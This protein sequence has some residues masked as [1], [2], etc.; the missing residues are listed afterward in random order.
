MS[1]F[2]S[3][4]WRHGAAGTEFTF[5]YVSILMGIAP[6]QGENTDYI[7]IPICFYFNEGTVRS[8]KNRY[9]IYIPICFYFNMEFHV[10]HTRWQQIYIPICFYF[11]V[12]DLKFDTN[13]TEFTFQY[14]SILI[15]L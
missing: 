11:N 6:A 7:Y 12:L 1:L 15:S 5:Q 4:G 3:A 10:F 2:K 13:I 9:K 8:W 14:V